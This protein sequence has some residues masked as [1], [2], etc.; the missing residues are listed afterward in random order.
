MTRT[1]PILDMRPDGTFQDG[2]FRAGPSP[3][4]AGQPFRAAPFRVPVSAKLMIGGALVAAV[5]VSLAVAFLAIWLVSMILP[6]VIIAGGVAWAAMRMRRWRSG[7][8]TDGRLQP[9]RFGQ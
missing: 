7:G 1:P 8:G 5:G 6:V 3:Q 2:T 4:P 9:R